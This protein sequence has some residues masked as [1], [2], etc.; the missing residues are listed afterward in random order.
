MDMILN[1]EIRRAKEISS[2]R[3]LRHADDVTFRYQ[4][5]QYGNLSMDAAT[6]RAHFREIL[7]DRH[8]LVSPSA[9]DRARDMPTLAHTW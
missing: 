2:H 6:C 7:P 8:E 5:T 3:G 9:T 4:F 1:P